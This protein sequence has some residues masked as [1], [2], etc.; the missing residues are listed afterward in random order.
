MCRRKLRCQNGKPLLQTFQMPLALLDPTLQELQECW[1]I[2]L[3]ATLEGLAHVCQGLR[4]GGKVFGAVEA[5]FFEVVEQALDLVRKKYNQVIK[6]WKYLDRSRKR[7]S[8]FLSATYVNA[9]RGSPTLLEL[10]CFCQRSRTTRKSA[11]SNHPK[12]SPL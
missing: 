12:R 3:P 1:G 2:C 7:I 8:E 10:H 5:G 9:R 11:E 4:N 6:Q